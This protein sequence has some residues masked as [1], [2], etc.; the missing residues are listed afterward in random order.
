VLHAD[1]QWFSNAL[2]ISIHNSVD[3]I[4]IT[5]TSTTEINTCYHQNKSKING[6]FLHTLWTA[7][8]A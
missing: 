1:I 2:R 3:T 8:W 5:I 7:V 4:I 6:T